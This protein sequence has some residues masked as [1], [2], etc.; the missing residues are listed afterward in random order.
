MMQVFDFEAVC[1]LTKSEYYLFKLIANEH[2]VVFLPRT[3][4]HRDAGRPNIRYADNYL[5]N[6]LA[7]IVK[8]GA[9]EFRFHQDFSESRVKSIAEQIVTD[10]QLGFAAGFRVTYQNRTLISN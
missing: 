10:P 6:A 2:G 7:A 1:E 3:T 8:P 5:G 4:E 9:I